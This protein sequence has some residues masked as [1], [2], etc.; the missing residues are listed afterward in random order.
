MGSLI[1]SILFLAALGAP[2]V[3][4]VARFDPRL[5]RV[6]RWAFGFPLG[7]VTG[8]LALLAA[9]S[10]V[11][12]L[13]VVVV[14]GVAVAA[15]AV[16][17]A[18]AWRGRGIRPAAAGAPIAAGPAAVLAILGLSMA[19][20]WLRAVALDSTGLWVAHVN[21]W[22]DW[23]QHL[24]D[25][26]TFSYGE[27]FPPRHPRLAGAPFA[28]HYLTSVTVAAMVRLGMRPVDALPLHSF[29]FS[30]TVLFAVFAFARRLTRD[31]AAA[32]VATVLLVGGGGLGWWLT[33]R[34]AASSTEP[35]RVLLATP[36]S[37]SAQR[38]G[39]FRW[40]NVFFSSL[41]PQRSW[42]YGLPLGLLTLTW[43]FEGVEDRERRLFV[44]AGIV[45]GLLP[46]AHLGTLLSF[47]IL[48]PALVLAF[49]TRRWIGF[50]ATW[51][52]VGLP[53]VLFQQGGGPG[54]LSALRFKPG[55]VAAPDSWV[56]FWAKNLGAFLPLLGFALARRGLMPR[57]GARF[58]WPF[59]GLFA[60]AN[61]VIFQ[62][63]DWDNTKVLVWWY[64]ASCVLVAALMARLWRE[65]ASIPARALVVVVVA[66]LLLS[67]TLEGAASLLGRDRQRMLSPEEVDLAERI[68]A[69]TA[70]R[71]V[72]AA[73]L[74]HNN[75]VSV[76][77]GRRVIL[78]YPGWMWSQGMDAKAREGD[79]RKIFALDTGAPAILDRYA[80]DYVA[81]GPKERKEL[82]ADL[83]VW[84]AR[85]PAVVRTENWEVFDVRR[86]VP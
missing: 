55:W 9:A 71:S 11:G 83:D 78:G 62:P 85:F 81:V 7:V 58:L 12:R 39:N 8:S 84:R 44:A 79:L 15:I 49:P 3:A 82:G 6:E 28:Y 34:G 21:L 52:A 19:V 5:D 20:F 48:M 54:A 69:S 40:L 22:G 50:L 60:V 4:A 77:A 18:I 65:H 74:A 25:V 61:V 41:A 47:A 72:F 46:F 1:A 36:W 13:S 29:L 75:P 56:W 35:L 42:L 27:N 64:L 33:L 31:A 63:W 59:M 23:A 26:T 14:A 76:L 73:G 2:G 38:E 37:F 70:P 86:P 16:A 51:A 30:L 45:A 53:Q 17:A 66:T 10:V 57:P 80:V 68:R 67:G 24:G 43:L 32:A